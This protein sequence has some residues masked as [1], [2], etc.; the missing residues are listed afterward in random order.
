MSLSDITS[1]QP[2]LDAIAEFNR[3]KR[4]KFLKKYGF[5]PSRS[6]W[7]VHD[8]QRYDSKAIVGVAHGYARPDL[9]PLTAKEFSGGEASI[10]RKLEQL[11]FRVD[12]DNTTASTIDFTSKQLIPE[13]IYT[14]DDL[15]KI[16]EI[17]DS[18]INTGIFRPKG[19]SS[20]W[21]FITDKK[22]SDRT[23]YINRLAGNILYCQGQKLGRKD[24]MIID[25]E[26]RGL[27]LLVFFR[28]SKDEYSGA[29]F[30]YLGPFIYL[31][32]EGRKPTSFVLGRKHNSATIIPSGIPDEDVFDP[33]SLKDAREKISR[34]ITQ[35]HGQRP[36]RNALIVAYGGQCAITGYSILDVLEAAHIHP[37]L[38]P[39]T[40]KVTNGLLLRS[41][42]HTLFDYGLV[43]I[44]SETMTVLVAP[45]LKDSEYG[46][47]HGAPVHIPQHPAEQPSTE[48]LEMHRKAAGL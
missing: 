47:F 27:E 28:K 10:G 42:V 25:H 17:R 15:K 6:Y 40:N 45:Q 33:T 23:P 34:S 43:A 11:G 48:A 5:G 32:H 31:K 37:Y 29:G 1:P 8:D 38:G 2:I 30:R 19:T 41:D 14:R 9:G 22:T 36:F 4:D 39:D 12:V 18:T 3:L 44:D 26:A 7:L 20:V 13:K 16:F 35:R 46:V 21:L 24:G